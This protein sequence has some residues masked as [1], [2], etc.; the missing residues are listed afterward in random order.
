MQKELT[1]HISYKEKILKK[2]RMNVLK[3]VNEYPCRIEWKFHS[4]TQITVI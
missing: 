2:K 1:M 4:H 3:K